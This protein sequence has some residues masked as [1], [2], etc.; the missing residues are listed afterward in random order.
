MLS[1]TQANI[2]KKKLEIAI[3]AFG[4]HYKII[5]PYLK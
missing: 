5:N 1:S 2:A 3:F 4:I